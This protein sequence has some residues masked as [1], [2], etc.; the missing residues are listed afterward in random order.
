M[1]SP[2]S[3]LPAESFW[4][5]GV[6]GA[7]SGDF[8]GLFKPRFELTPEMR[9]ATAGSCFAQHVGRHLRG[10]GF[11][12]LDAEPPPPGLS[13]EEAR[14]FGFELYSARHGNIYTVRQMLQ[15]ALEAFGRFTPGDAV[16]HRDGRFYDALRPT[17]EPNGLGSA[18]A[19]RQHRAAH[20]SRV[21]SVLREADVLVFTMGLV[22]AWVHQP[23][24]TVYPTAPGV[25]ADSDAPEDI[26]L[27]SFDFSEIRSD[28][29]TLRRLLVKFNRKLRFLLTVSPVPLTATATD[30][31]VLVA[32]MYAKS[33]LRAV[34]GRVRQEC[35]DVDYFPSYEIVAGHPSRGRFYAPNMREVTSE[36]V[37]CVMRHFTAAYQHVPES[38]ASPE[39][40]TPPPQPE[41]TAEQKAEELVCDEL[42]LEAFAATQGD[43]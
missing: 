12:V 32:T 33:T 2:Y 19:V 27:H 6:A 14:R 10:L 24:G 3:G 26:V 37:A 16:W 28:L 17:V 8:P 23:T 13:G 21:R 35:P 36:G 41:Q 20:L 11:R 34:A 22:E 31:H 42:L 4:R 1:A 9:I 29:L 7:A 15:L 5:S 30:D 25:V 18:E 40:A 43:R 38:P 39:P